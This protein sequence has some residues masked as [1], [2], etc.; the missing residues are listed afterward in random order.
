[1]LLRNA[2]G[3]GDTFAIEANHKVCHTGSHSPWHYAV[4]YSITDAYIT[5]WKSDA[6]NGHKGSFNPVCDY[7][8]DPSEVCLQLQA[9]IIPRLFWLSSQLW[10][11]QRL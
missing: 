10:L 11:G 5:F 2:A 7:Y 6:C 1:M 3:E 8:D 4:I 9:T